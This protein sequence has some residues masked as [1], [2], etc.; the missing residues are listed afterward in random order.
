[1]FPLTRRHGAHSALIQVTSVEKLLEPNR[2]FSVFT[3]G[4]VDRFVRLAHGALGSRSSPRAW[5]LAA[6]RIAWLHEGSGEQRR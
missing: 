3:H 5:L 2:L 6:L 1:S 4:N